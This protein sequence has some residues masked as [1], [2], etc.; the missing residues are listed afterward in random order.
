MINSDTDKKYQAN[1]I[2]EVLMKIQNLINS[3]NRNENKVEQIEQIML[4]LGTAIY[5][6]LVSAILLYTSLFFYFSLFLF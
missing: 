1:D 3:I 4:Y 6:V 5:A 2:N